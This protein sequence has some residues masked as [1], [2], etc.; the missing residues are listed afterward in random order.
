VLEAVHPLAVRDAERRGR[1]IA[2]ELRIV[3]VHATEAVR[4]AGYSDRIDPDRWRPLMMSFQH[5][6]GLGER[7]HASTLSKIPESAYRPAPVAAP[8][9]ERSA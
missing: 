3:R 5:F 4:L 6:Y 7:V 1:S 9:L 8:R 2:L